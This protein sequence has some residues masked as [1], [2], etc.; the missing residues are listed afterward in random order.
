MT[1]YQPHE[2]GEQPNKPDRDANGVQQFT[3]KKA[4]P[5]CPPGMVYVPSTGE[6]IPPEGDQ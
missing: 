4:M 6:C 2:P 3:T 1:G 5:K